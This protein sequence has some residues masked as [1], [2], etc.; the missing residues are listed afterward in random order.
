M[1]K[2]FY[3]VPFYQYCRKKQWKVIRK[4]ST[5]WKALLCLRKAEGFCVGALFR[6]MPVAS[7]IANWGNPGNWPGIKRP[8]QRAGYNNVSHPHHHIFRYSPRECLDY[9]G[10]FSSRLTFDGADSAFHRLVSVEHFPS[11]QPILKLVAK[12]NAVRSENTRKWP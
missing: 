1:T 5:W 2:S 4:S 11:S 3:I 10:A 9:N 12:G 8:K 6:Y 7:E